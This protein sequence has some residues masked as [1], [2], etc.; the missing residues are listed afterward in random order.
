MTCTDMIKKTHPQTCQR[1]R[2]TL[3]FVKTHEMVQSRLQSAVQNNQGDKQKETALDHPD[4]GTWQEGLNIVS[5]I[6]ILQVAFIPNQSSVKLSDIVVHAQRIK[7][8]SAFWFVRISCIREPLAFV[9]PCPRKT[10][11]YWLLSSLNSPRACCITR[12]FS[13]WLSFNMVLNTGTNYLARSGDTSRTVIWCFLGIP[14]WHTP[15]LFLSFFPAFELIKRIKASLSIHEHLLQK[16]D[17]TY[18]L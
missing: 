9:Y 3:A 8:N 6:V 2:L 14:S 18:R 17:A 5:W 13:S 4:L 10:T 15:S 12:S 16:L 1:G 11:C 7:Q